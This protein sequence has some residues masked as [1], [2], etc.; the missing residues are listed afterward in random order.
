MHKWCIS[1]GNVKICNP[2][3]EWSICREH[4][5]THTHTQPHSMN[6]VLK[7]QKEKQTKRKQDLEKKW[8]LNLNRHFKPSIPIRN[9]SS[10]NN[11][12]KT[13]T[14]KLNT[15]TDFLRMEGVKKMCSGHCTVQVSPKQLQPVSTVPEPPPLSEPVHNTPRRIGSHVPAVKL[16]L[17]TM[18]WRVGSLA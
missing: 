2:Y 4:T 8:R 1:F 3:K 17:I 9:G 5:H 12:N 6:T 13:H 18:L 15:V 14:K 7:H 11:D 10:Y 16:D